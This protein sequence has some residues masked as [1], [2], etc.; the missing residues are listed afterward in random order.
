M[1]NGGYATFF[2]V[3]TKNVNSLPVYHLL[4]FDW[5]TLISTKIYKKS[6]GMALAS[7]GAIVLHEFKF[8]AHFTFNE[9]PYG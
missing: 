3:H 8:Y 1:E 4:K 9:T 6:C 7:D 2:Q 5:R